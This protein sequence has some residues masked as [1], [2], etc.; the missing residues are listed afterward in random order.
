M[1]APVQEYGCCFLLVPLIDGFY[2][3]RFKIISLSKFALEFLYNV[4]K[5]SKHEDK[6]KKY[7]TCLP[8][9]T[10]FRRIASLT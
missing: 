10:Y 1:T 7:N 2:F 9:V 3:V 8:L 6:K 5:L 4:F